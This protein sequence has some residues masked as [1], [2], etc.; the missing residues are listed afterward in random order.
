MVDIGGGSTELVIGE[1]FRV[2]EA[3]SV[4]MGCVTFSRRFFENGRLS[5][6]AFERA[7]IAARVEL[8]SIEDRFKATGFVEAVGSSGTANAV[9][10][11]LEQNGW[12]PSGITKSGLGQLENAL[13]KAGQIE[14]LTLPGLSEDRQPVIAG[15]IAVLA[16]VFDALELDSMAVSSQALREGLLYDLIGRIHHED[17]R[18]STISALQNRYAVDLEPVSYTHL[19]LP[20]ILRV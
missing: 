13:V 15:G 5:R 10:T 20:T 8:L 19:T 11:I 1:R 18:D 16:A 7:R 17:V 2:F 3:D 12:S 6:R 4:Q 9:A 14:N